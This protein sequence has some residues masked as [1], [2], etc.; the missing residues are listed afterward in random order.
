MSERPLL[1]I[2]EEQSEPRTYIAGTQ[3]I[4]KG[5]R[6]SPVNGVLSAEVNQNSDNRI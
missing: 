1:S 5:N 3:Q 6:V 4:A 2:D